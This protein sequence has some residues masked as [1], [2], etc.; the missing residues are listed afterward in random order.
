[1]YSFKLTDTEFEFVI[2]FT[3]PNCLVYIKFF[4]FVYDCFKK[5]KK[6]SM[7]KSGNVQYF[8]VLV[9]KYLKKNRNGDDE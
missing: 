3:T 9:K 5:M 1:M 8:F 4:L 7:K 2:S 6:I